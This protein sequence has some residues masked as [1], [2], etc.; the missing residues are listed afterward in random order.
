MN[1]VPIEVGEA[2]GLM[3]LLVMKIGRDYKLIEYI[4]SP[5]ATDGRG[6][7]LWEIVV[8]IHRAIVGM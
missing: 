6:M 4:D 7:N 5:Y 2:S 8:T 1:I 3:V